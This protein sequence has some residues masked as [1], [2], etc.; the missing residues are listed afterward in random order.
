[1]D[2]DARI[3]TLAQKFSGLMYVRWRELKGDINEKIIEQNALGLGEDAGP[4]GG[5]GFGSGIRFA[6]D[7]SK[8]QEFMDWLHGQIREGV[9][10]PVGYQA[11]SNG[12]HFSGPY[13]RAANSSGIRDAG[14]RMRQAGI[15][16]D[17]GRDQL[18]MVFNLP[19]R[20]DQLARLYRRCFSEY[21]DITRDVETAISEELT[22][23]LAL[24]E[25]P[26]KVASR[27]NDRVDAIGITRSRT[28]ARTEL[29]NSYNEGSKLRYAR[30]GIETVRIQ[31]TTPCKEI[32]KPIIEDGPYP[33]DD[34][35]KGG[36]PL[37]P[38]CE[39]TISPAILSELDNAE[40]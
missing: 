9:L 24:G 36:P 40:S 6:D 22:E 4:L 19:V 30:N 14:T 31:N 8:K 20:Q 28:L 5:D 29:S 18:D 10:E 1:M 26:R 16:P 15:E 34:I 21:Q 38:N 27:L 13:I 12:G 23:A 33:L 11:L 37:H 39:G 25:N 17:L 3:K 32:C 2:I 35:P 7:A